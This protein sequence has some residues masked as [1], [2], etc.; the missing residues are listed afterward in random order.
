[1][2]F[3][4]WLLL[5][6]ACLICS[7]IDSINASTRWRICSISSCRVAMM[8]NRECNISCILLS[9]YYIGLLSFFCTMIHH[10]SQF[11]NFCVW[12]WF[13]FHVTFISQRKFFCT[14][15]TCVGRTFLCEW[16]EPTFFTH[17]VR[18]TPILFEAL[19]WHKR[20]LDACKFATHT[21]SR[22]W[23]SFCSCLLFWWHNLNVVFVFA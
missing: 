21:T 19:T 3:L 5:V 7:A 8:H 12:V 15:W 14:A 11:N 10:P 16:T 13:C 18:N 23:N 4:L 20:I 6:V 2:Q 22:W 1:M 9:F 17:A